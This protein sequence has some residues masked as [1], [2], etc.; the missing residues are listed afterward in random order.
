MVDSETH[1]ASVLNVTTCRRRSLNVLSRQSFEM[2]EFCLN[3]GRM[4]KAVILSNARRACS[5]T[6][7]T[8][9][10]TNLIELSTVHLDA[11]EY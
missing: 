4:A 7:R 11:M 5:V 2:L 8:Y 1:V 3:G 10:V 9:I 6:V